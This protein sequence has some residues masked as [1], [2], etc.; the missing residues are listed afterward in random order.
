MTEEDFDEFIDQEI[1]N[2]SPFYIKKVEI[3]T[4]TETLRQTFQTFNKL[5]LDSRVY[6]ELGEK[7]KKKEKK[8]EEKVKERPSQSPRRYRILRRKRK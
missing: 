6:N 1:T 7:S 5:I 8:I 4:K 2:H 3:I